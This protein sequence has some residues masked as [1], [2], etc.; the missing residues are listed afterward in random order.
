M[1]MYSNSSFFST[2]L[3]RNVNTV[4]EQAFH[5]RSDIYQEGWNHNVWVRSR[6]CTIER[7]HFYL[8]QR[9]ADSGP[10]RNNLFSNKTNS[11]TI[12]KRFGFVSKTISE[13]LSFRFSP[14]AIGRFGPVDVQSW[15]HVMQFLSY[16]S[17]Y[18]YLAM[19]CSFTPEWTWFA[20]LHSRI[21]HP[22][23]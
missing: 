15:L 12:P 5:K 2:T 22:R 10:N 23:H 21:T 8:V 1:F 6:I 11:G 17:S 13:R 3:C 4:K 9:R 18:L 7:D 16:C 20:A 14:P 19:Q